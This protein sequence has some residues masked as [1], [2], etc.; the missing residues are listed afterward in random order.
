MTVTH[1]TAQHQSQVEMRGLVSE[2]SDLESQYLAQTQSITD[3]RGIELGLT[4]P[5]TVA[6]IYTQAGGRQLSLQTVQ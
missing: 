6:T 2:I 4:K 1:A 5:I 3:D